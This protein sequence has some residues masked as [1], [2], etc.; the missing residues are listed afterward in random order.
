[1]PRLL[2]APP[3]DQPNPSKNQFRYVQRV[4]AFHSTLNAY[5]SRFYLA[6]SK[7][8]SQWGVFVLNHLLAALHHLLFALYHLPSTALRPQVIRLRIW[9]STIPYRR[10]TS[11][12]NLGLAQ[13][14]TALL[15]LQEVI[16]Q[17]I[18]FQSPLGILPK[19]LKPQN[20]LPQ[21]IIH[22]QIPLQYP[23]STTRKPL[24]RQEPIPRDIIL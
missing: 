10:S 19:P 11:Q 13:R 7:I 18:P 17:Q 24:K 4:K 1:M 14:K 8:T 20:I 22:Q 6:E 2:L 12:T 23:P 5:W 9:N 3:L 15:N 21:E 16:L